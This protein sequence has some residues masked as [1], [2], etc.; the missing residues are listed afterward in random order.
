MSDPDYAARA[1]AFLDLALVKGQP[2]AAVDEFVGSS[3]RQHSPGVGDGVDAFIEFAEELGREYP[4]LSLT[5]HRTISQGDM[6]ALHTEVRGLGTDTDGNELIKAAV[7][8]YRFD[9]DG[10]IAEHWEVIQDVPAEARHQN[11]MF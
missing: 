10:K 6:V 5:I 8:M 11:G 3:Y 1:I 4:N 9:A 7:D 2:R